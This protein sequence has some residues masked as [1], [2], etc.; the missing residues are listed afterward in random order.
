MSSKRFVISHN[1]Y[2]REAISI[3]INKGNY[4]DSPLYRDVYKVKLKYKYLKVYLK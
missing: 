2:H 1:V 3:I 4:C